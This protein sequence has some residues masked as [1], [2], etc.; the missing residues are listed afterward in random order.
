MNS[1][2]HVT[3]K[4]RELARYICETII[5]FTDCKNVDYEDETTLDFDDGPKYIS[6]E[7]DKN[8]STDS[9]DEAD[10]EWE[11][12]ENEK[13]SLTNYT[14]TFMQNAVAYADETDTFGERCRSWKS[15]HNRYKLLPSQGYVSRCRQYIS[16]QGTKRQKI[17]DIRQL[18]FKK[19]SDAREKCLPVHDVDIQRWGFKAA[20]ELNV[21]NFHASH[22]WLLDFKRKYRIVSR[23]V[24]NIVTHHQVEDHEIIQKSKK[25]FLR[26]F[27]ALS[28]R[29][30]SSQIINTD[31]TGIEKETYSTR[32]LSFSGEK[33]TYGAVASKNATTHSYT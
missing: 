27:F 19:F 20:K 22:H 7:D 25:E 14:L 16:Q 13:E 2:F 17:E 23:R 9:L 24:T 4:E 30:S 3:P 1:I 12:K 11:N 33:K 26:E 28:C 32:T 5:S 31:Q 15:I 29:Y 8:H 6:C 18:V 21:G 10:D